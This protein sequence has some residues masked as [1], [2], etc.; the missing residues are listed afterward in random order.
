MTE[1]AAPGATAAGRSGYDVDGVLLPR[2]FKIRR[3]GH[4][5]FNMANLDDGI[6]FYV[7][8]LGFRITDRVSLF[9]E[10][11]GRALEI[12]EKVVTD[13][14]MVFTSHG[15]D[16]H[17]LLLAHKTFGTFNRNDRYA[18]DNTLSQITWQVGTLR[19]VAEA[20]GYLEERQIKISMVGRDMPGGNWHV[21]FYDPDGNT[22][23]LY[24][25]MEQIGWN[26]R[27]RPREMHYRAFRR[28]PELPQMSEA[29]ELR[30]A[31]ERGID[32][33]SGWRPDESRLPEVHDVG[34]IL[35]AR[36]F[37][38]TNLGPVSMFTERLDEMVAFYTDVL[39]FTETERTTVGSGRVVFLRV[40]TEHHSFVLAE[41]VLRAEL[42]LSE[43]SSNLAIG[44]QVGGYRQLRDAVAH[45]TDKGHTFVDLPPELHLG[46]DYAAHLRDPDGHLVQ[47][48]FAMEQVGWDGRP[49]P[50]ELR[51]KVT[52]PWPEVLEPLSDTYA[53][54]A[55]L[56]PLG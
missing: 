15:S 36:P 29:A 54:H 25:G 45:L 24:Y 47:L 11:R 2:P 34:G 40:G 37:K 26:R 3:F 12:A 28:M 32:L 42:G 56:G 38:I 48:Y 50:A 10:V 55:Y 52:K 27:S 31:L 8:E 6:T 21:Y 5:G 22:V 30:E 49:R 41:K 39:G 4:F 19:E 44:M 51:R 13:P 23:E 14:R 16:H 20:I 53:D 1:P 33:D 18:P 7:D 46:I 17:A 35:L 9:D 43:H